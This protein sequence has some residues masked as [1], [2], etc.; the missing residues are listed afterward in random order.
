MTKEYFLQLA[1]Y[2]IWA[3]D[4]VHSWLNK[5]TDEQW[6]C[7][8]I[9]SFDSIAETALHI[10]SAER[11]W[12]ERLNKALAP[13]WLQSDFKGSKNDVLN[14]WNSASKNLRSFVAN[15]DETQLQSILSFK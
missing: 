5:I 1:D 2:N 9:S 12:H 15:F 11:V 3:N 6:K 13:A 8:V 7:T 4:R 14:E 10:A